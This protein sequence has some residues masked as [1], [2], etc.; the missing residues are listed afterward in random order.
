MYNSG[1]PIQLIL[2]SF[3]ANTMTGKAPRSTIQVRA[4]REWGN[5]VKQFLDNDIDRG[6]GV[7]YPWLWHVAVLQQDRWIQVT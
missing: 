4:R 2:F 3:P 1:T 6:K 5:F 7:R